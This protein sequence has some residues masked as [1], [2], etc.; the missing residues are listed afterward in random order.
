M[1][2]FPPVNPIFVQARVALED[3]EVGGVHI[4]KG[5]PVVCNSLGMAYDPQI[6]KDPE[7]FRPERFMDGSDDG[8][9]TRSQFAYIPFGAGPHKCI[10][11]K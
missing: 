11:Y 6:Y 2:L 5:T 8:P 3:V 4:P 10:G 1:R 9:E 7:E